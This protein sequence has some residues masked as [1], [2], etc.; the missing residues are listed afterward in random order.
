[1]NN[2]ALKLSKDLPLSFIYWLPRLVYLQLLWFL[3]VLPII[4]L[5]T[6]SRALL[7]SLVDCQQQETSLNAIYEIYKSNFKMRFLRKIKLDMVY[8]LY[9]LF[10]FIDSFIFWHW[11]NSVGNISFYVVTLVIWFTTLIFIYQTLASK[12]KKASVSFLYS[13][14]VFFKKPWLVF[15]H[16]ALPLFSFICLFFV[17]GAYLCL[18]G[19]SGFFWLNMKI[20]QKNTLL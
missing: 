8:G 2:T 18:A 11:H 10:M 16:T 9:F 13:F 5:A 14:Y 15:L 6:A 1:M 20:A 19:A 4:T 12:Q 3:S 7:D 17:G